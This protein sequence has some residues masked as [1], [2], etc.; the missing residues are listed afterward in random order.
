MDTNT[1]GTL[2]AWTAARTERHER[3]H[4]WYTV[5]ICF[6][7]TMIVYG[8]LSHAYSMSITFALLAGLFFLVRNSDSPQHRI[9]LTTAGID[10]DDRF[11]S[12]SEWKHFWILQGDGYFELHIEA[13][14]YLIPDLVIRTGSIDPLVVR[15][16]VSQFVP[17]ID[18]RKE[19]ILDA[20]IRFCKI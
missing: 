5:S 19:N 9:A 18:H 7:A 1:Q 13:K 12:W 10:F 20:I 4:R 2:L 14:K 3:S 17:Q 6:V 15:D 16:T 11:T 8:V